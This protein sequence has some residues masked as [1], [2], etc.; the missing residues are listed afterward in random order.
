MVNK[1]FSL[2]MAWSLLTILL[3]I[4]GCDTTNPID[5]NIT[6]VDN[7]IEV[8]NNSLPNNEVVSII[9]NFAN[10]MNIPESNIKE[11]SID[12]YN[13]AEYNY[14]NYD[15]SYYHTVSWYTIAGNWLKDL[16]DMAQILD[17]WYVYYLWDEIWWAVIQYSKDNI[18]CNYY[19]SLEQEIPMELMEREWDLNDE[20]E[21]EA[22]D[23]ARSDFYEKA[24]YTVEFSCGFAPEWMA[25]YKDFSFYGEW[26]EPFWY[27]SLN[28]THINIFTPDGVKEQYIDTLKYDWENIEFKW[29]NVNWKLEKSDCIDW[30]KWDTH[31]YTISFD[32]NKYSYADDGTEYN[33]WP[34]HYEWCADK[35]DADFII[36]EEWTI[37]TII[38]KTNYQYTRWVDHD[39]VSYTVSDIAWKYMNLNIYERLEDTYSNYQIIMEKTDDGRKVIFEWD[40]YEISDEQCEELNQYDNNL[41]DMF[42]LTMCPRG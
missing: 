31:E 13:A 20:S 14:D 39:K 22:Y 37:D 5:N 21:M 2:L 15:E 4:T 29:Y 6:D 11:T 16:P 17:W 27:A 23:K 34:I 3:V 26:M 32:V 28:W 7:N 41:M 9:K 19:N 33:E 10:E 8:D 25:Q 36:W 40:W 12:W 24:T 1:K 38:N 30:W 35:I 42:F 18:I